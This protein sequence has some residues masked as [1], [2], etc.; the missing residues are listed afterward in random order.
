MSLHL[1]NRYTPANISNSADESKEWREQLKEC[2]GG[3]ELATGKPVK[4]AV[5][6]TGVSIPGADLEYQFHNRLKECRSWLDEKAGEEGIEFQEVDEDGHGTHTVSIALKTTERT[7]CELYVAQVFR[8]RGEKK[9]VYTNKATQT[10]IARVSI[11]NK[12]KLPSTPS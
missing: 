1:Q 6:D 12:R 8:N 7:D 9:T 11:H 4:M 2:L 5:I 10:A 3:Y